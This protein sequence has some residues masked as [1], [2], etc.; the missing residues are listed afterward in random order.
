MIRVLFW[1]CAIPLVLKM[2]CYDLVHGLQS[3]FPDGLLAVFEDL[4][5]FNVRFLRDI[6]AVYLALEALRTPTPA[7]DVDML[8][9]CTFSAFVAMFD[10]CRSWLA[11]VLVKM[12][13]GSPRW[14]MVLGR[15]LH[16]PPLYRLLKLVVSMWM[17]FYGGSAYV[18]THFISRGDT[19]TSFPSSSAAAA[20]GVKRR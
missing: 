16:K 13:A 15:F 17:L 5:W 19:T 6:G 4:C 14:C 1:V 3:S 8:V 2:V 12:P 20:A 11:R 18:A 9:F 7:D 10:E